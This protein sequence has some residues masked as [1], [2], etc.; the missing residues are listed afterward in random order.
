MPREYKSERRAE[1]Q[2]LHTAGYTVQGIAH[3]MGIAIR[4][5]Q[6]AMHRHKL[7]TQQVVKLELSAEEIELLANALTA[8]GELRALTKST[9]DFAESFWLDNTDNFDAINA[10]EAAR[11]L[12]KNATQ[13]FYSLRKALGVNDE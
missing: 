5:V 9:L 13:F 3:E 2:R 7:R 11:E 4:S 10:V 12:Y 8:A 1:V 6:K